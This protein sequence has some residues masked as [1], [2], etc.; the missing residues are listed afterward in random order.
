VSL[1]HKLEDT[2]AAVKVLQLTQWHIDV[3]YTVFMDI[4]LRHDNAEHMLSAIC[5]KNHE[6]PVWRLIHNSTR[7]RTLIQQYMYIVL[8]HYLRFV[9]FYDD[10][11]AALC[12]DFDTPTAI[13]ALLDLIKCVHKYIHEKV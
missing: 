10:M 9:A 13:K 5:S 3:Y 11:Q 12:D 7:A 6:M 8:M 4:T 1:A 2:K